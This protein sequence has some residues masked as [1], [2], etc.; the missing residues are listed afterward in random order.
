MS[1]MHRALREL[2]LLDIGQCQFDIPL[3]EHSRWRI[4]GPAD[5]LVTPGSIRQVQT[6]RRALHKYNIPHV[7]IGD[8]SNLLFDDEGVTG[9]VVKIGRALSCFSFSDE[10]IDAEAGVFVP[11][12]VRCASKY[13]LGGIEHTIGIPGTLGGLILMNGG[14]MQQGIGSHIERVR[15]V[16]IE[17]DLVE[18]SQDACRFAYRYSALQEARVVIV[19]ARLRC[20]LNEPLSMRREMVGIMRSRRT[21]FPIRQPN[22]GSVFLSD[23]V[24]YETVGPPGKLIEECG[25]KGLRIGDAMIPHI[26]ANFIVNLGN[27]KSSD[28]LQLIE[29]VRHSVHSRF[30][31]LMS[32]EVR[33]VM[34]NCQVVPAH[35]AFE[36]VS[37]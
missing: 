12:L 5:L 11:K 16:N 15:A 31:Y 1:P 13:G 10:F 7:I 30:G 28:V 26:H 4:G 8:G 6:L 33:C 2:T 19:E 34:P 18:Y 14:S 29:M 32:C 17:G 24:M 23:P 22:C 21:K 27:A 37:E 36:G 25:L 3:R 20:N 35:Y 9:V